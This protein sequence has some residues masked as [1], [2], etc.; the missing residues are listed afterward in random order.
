MI[1]RDESFI[2]ETLETVSRMEPNLFL[3][4]LVSSPIA[5]LNLITTSKTMY[6]VISRYDDNNAM[7]NDI[8]MRLVRNET[9]NLYF[10]VH[11]KEYILY[12]EL[13]E[14]FMKKY[15]DI[16]NNRIR[17]IK[18]GQV[19]TGIIQ[20]Y[21]A[22]NDDIIHTINNYMGHIFDIGEREI[23]NFKRLYDGKNTQYD[24]TL[25]HLV[26][27]IPLCF[28]YDMNIQVIYNNVLVICKTIL[29]CIMKITTLPFENAIV[30]KSLNALVEN[31]IKCR[32]TTNTIHPNF[33]EKIAN[34][35]EGVQNF[36]FIMNKEYISDSSSLYK[37]E[38]TKIEEACQFLFQFISFQKIY[39]LEPME[40]RYKL[41]IEKLYT[42]QIINYE[43]Y[44]S[45]Y[46]HQK[47][48]IL[49]YELQS[50][51]K[52]Q[53]TTESGSSIESES[54]SSVEPSTL[55]VGDSDDDDD[56]IQIKDED[57]EQLKTQIIEYVNRLTMNDHINLTLND[58]EE[59][60]KRASELDHDDLM[61]A[62]GNQYVEKYDKADLIKEYGSPCV[63]CSLL[64]TYI[65]KYEL[66]KN[67]KIVYYCDH[68]FK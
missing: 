34:F 3:D 5:L 7:W 18:H 4:R 33:K 65:S 63:Q 35:Y 57:E 67:N 47:K 24:N 48:N 26:R 38:K 32:L 44:R 54:D 13:Y 41:Y 56:D 62:Y 68:C 39:H 45:S 23:I 8:L 12:S 40:E 46:I 53:S 61:L 55:S 59:I 50:L 37:E 15:N 58:Y 9:K 21:P 6:S 17:Y 52:T 27:H 11:I 30:V 14:S 51:I 49:L 16:S 1:R 25:I 31:N 43:Y 28:Y 66:E 60:N 22:L 64:T 10:L 42:K 20:L 2:P 19:V 36:L 29:L